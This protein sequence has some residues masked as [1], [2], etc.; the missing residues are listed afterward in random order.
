MTIGK[1][2]IKPVQLAHVTTRTHDEGATRSQQLARLAAQ[3]R[4]FDRLDWWTVSEWAD[5]DAWAW[6]GDAAMLALPSDIGVPDAIVG[7]RM[8]VAWVRWCA[9]MDGVSAS[10]VVRDLFAQTMQRL[11][12]AGISELWCI[13]DPSDW[14]H[15]YLR[16]HGFEGVDRMLTFRIAEIPH[17]QPLASDVTLRPAKLADLDAICALDAVV[18]DAPWRYPPTTMRRAMAQTP[19]VSVAVRDGDMIGYQCALLNEGHASG[20]IVRLAVAEPM[21]GQ[22]IARALLVDV[23][24]QLHR[25]GCRSFTLNTQQTNRSSQA[26]YARLGFRLLTDQPD[27]LR[28]RISTAAP[29]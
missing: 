3:R 19:F 2:I 28:K 4:V 17:A 25:A 8:R 22:G 27:V 9:I 10:G 1:T 24:Q 12:D 26:F 16:D 29:R 13:A 11:S 6:T 14:I 21:R 23:M 5:S 20:H 15:D 7:T 18:F